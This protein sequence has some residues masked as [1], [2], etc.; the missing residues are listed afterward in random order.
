M[1][2]GIAPEDVILQSE[3]IQ[4]LL[5][6]PLSLEAGQSLHGFQRYFLPDESPASLPLLRCASD[7]VA[8]ILRDVSLL[9]PCRSLEALLQVGH[10]AQC[11]APA[12]LYHMQWS[13]HK[14][15]E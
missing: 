2:L 9:R 8:P 10:T 11:A 15:S 5:G 4:R 14:L 7:L 12:S 3:G 13:S 6:L 1:N